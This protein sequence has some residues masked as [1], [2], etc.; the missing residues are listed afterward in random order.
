[1]GRQKVQTHSVSAS[2]TRERESRTMP[3]ETMAHIPGGTFFMGSLDSYPEEQAVHRVRVDEFWIDKIPVT[4]ASFRSFVEATGYVTLAE[5]SRSP[6]GVFAATPE[7]LVPGSLV[8]RNP[9]HRV[10]S[11]NY[12][13]WWEYVPGACWKH[14]EGPGS[15]L[16]GRE[17]H[18][19]VHVAYED[20]EA[21]AEWMGKGLPTEAEWEYAARG[22]L[23]CATLPWGDEF[24][25][26]GRVMA[27]KGYGEFRG[28]SLR[29]EEG[30]SAV[31]SY[32]PN[33][34]GLFDMCGNVWEWTCDSY[35]PDQRTAMAK[36]VRTSPGFPAMADL[37]VHL[38]QLRTEVVQ[39]VVKG[40][41]YW[42]ATNYSLRYTPSARQGALV[43]S[44]SSH[45]GFRCIVRTNRI[46]ETLSR[47]SVG[48]R[49]GAPSA[50]D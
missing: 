27:N 8:F 44:S 25:A 24:S 15:D 26:G 42:S 20:A 50:P 37:S 11:D 14:P 21:F 18:P 23:E 47:T 33:A 30:T 2:T 40:G 22:G 3:S 32:P 29:R 48:R 49:R 10:D 38:D 36:S 4:N 13:D 43:D 34:Y 28:W 7:M 9:A 45:V 46:G 12:T 16:R 6:K 5:R 31:G 17:Y 41:S 19:V 39:R 35:R 1:M